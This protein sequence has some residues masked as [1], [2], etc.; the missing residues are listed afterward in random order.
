[1]KLLA[2]LALAGMLLLPACSPSTPASSTLPAATT[3]A[4]TTASRAPVTRTPIPVPGSSEATAYPAPGGA[5][6]EDAYPAP[7]G[8]A[9]NSSRSSETLPGGRD[10][11]GCDRA[12][13]G[14]AGPDPASAGQQDED[15]E[16]CPAEGELSAH[17]QYTRGN[18]NM[19][20]KNPRLPFLT[21]TM[22]DVMI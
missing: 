1:M 21:D 6:P 15:R 14:S 13:W 10:A 22:Y 20:Y 8:E 3:P 17:L 9:A 16:E 7:A 5:A 11:P 2:W 19:E 4:S 12:V 18:F